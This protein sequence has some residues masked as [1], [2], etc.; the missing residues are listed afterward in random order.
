MLFYFLLLL[1]S[2]FRTQSLQTQSFEMRSVNALNES[3][4]QLAGQLMQGLRAIRRKRSRSLPTL[5]ESPSPRV[6]QSNQQLELS[7]S[8]TYVAFA[9]CDPSCWT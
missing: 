9:S 1:L 8:S 4:S 5:A 7:A 3:A 6:E 2:A